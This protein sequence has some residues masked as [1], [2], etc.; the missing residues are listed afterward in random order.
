MK[1]LKIF[2]HITDKDI[3][4]W[5]IS[6]EDLEDI[7]LEIRDL[8]PFNSWKYELK[9]PF[10]R[11]WVSYVEDKKLKRKVI[12]EIIF[13][14]RVKCDRDKVESAIKSVTNRLNYYNIVVDDHTFEH[15]ETIPE[16][17][18]WFVCLWMIHKDHINL[19]YRSSMY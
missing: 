7:L 10:N 2:E 9:V 19:K 15:S 17:N 16:K 14:C 11:K 13:L 12:P 1:Y 5:P 18:I 6:V 8:R 3:V 4:D